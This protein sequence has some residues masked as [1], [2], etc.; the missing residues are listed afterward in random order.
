MVLPFDYLRL[1]FVALIGF[2]FFAEA[3]GVF[4]WIG[5]GVIAAASGY[6]AHREATLARAGE[7]PLATTAPELPE[8]AR[9]PATESRR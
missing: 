5:A 2:A 8:A 3:P 4:T 7:A 6:L 9:P 1:P